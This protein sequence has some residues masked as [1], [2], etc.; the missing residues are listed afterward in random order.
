MSEKRDRLLKY[1]RLYGSGSYGHPYWTTDRRTRF[2]NI[3][4]GYGLD[5]IFHSWTNTLT[6]TVYEYFMEPNND[7]NYE[8]EKGF[9]KILNC[10]YIDDILDMCEQDTKFNKITDAFISE[11][12]NNFDFEEERRVWY[13]EAYKSLFPNS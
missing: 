13:E 3:C 1:F 9:C 10:P 6:N 5:C 11:V 4:N 7:A 8:P 12:E 2:R